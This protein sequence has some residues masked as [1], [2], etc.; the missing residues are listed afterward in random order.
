M[1]V[2]FHLNDG[3]GDVGLVIKDVVGTLGLAAG[4]KLSSNDDSAVGEG[5]LFANLKH[6]VPAGLRDGGADELGTDVA[7]AEVLLVHSSPFVQ[8]LGLQDS[9][10]D[11][12]FENACLVES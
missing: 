5:D 6:L 2:V 1:I 9:P 3:D 4:D 7:F 10:I 12:Q 8:R 11:S